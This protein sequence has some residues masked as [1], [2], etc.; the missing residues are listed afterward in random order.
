MADFKV[1]NLCGA[2]VKLNS[3]QSKFETMMKSSIDGLEV[4]A[5]ALTS[6][7]NTDVTSLVGDIKSMVPE[8]PALPDVNLQGQLTSLAGLSVGSG[9]HNT[10]L[11]SVTSKFGS[12][13][14]AG[15]FSL[16]SLVSDAASAISGG[17]DLCSAV[18]NFS[19]PAAG[20]AAVQKAVEVLQAEADSLPEKPS[21]LVANA[22][23][24]A[25]KTAV[26][27]TFAS[28]DEIGEEMPSEDIGPYRV[29][30]E[31]TKVVVSDNQ[32]STTTIEATTSQNSVGASTTVTT[33]TTIKTE[34]IKTSGGKVTERT[35]SNVAEKGF[36]RRTIRIKDNFL[37]DDVSGGI[38]NEFTLKNTPTSISSVWGFDP[39]ATD[40]KAI[41]GRVGRWRYISRQNST[42]ARRNF[43]DWWTLD[44]QQMT[45]TSHVRDYDTDPRSGYMFKV[46]YKTVDNYDPNFAGPM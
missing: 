1:P 17:T 18:P 29:S 14:T 12:G 20:G 46:K 41:R 34:T 38:D 28:Y 44:G 22:N 10:L 3:I 26:E 39:N 42:A 16:D 21:T 27:E 35:R 31:T 13:L 30:E 7:L 8:L 15:G 5:S 25:E 32:G 45:V 6:T 2:S 23:F 19:V 11:A 4:D 37:I 43:S 9:A 24:T 36:T 33:A 40:G